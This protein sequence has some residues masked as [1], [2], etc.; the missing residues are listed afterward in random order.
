MTPNGTRLDGK[1]RES[2]CFFQLGGSDDGE[3]A[4]FLAAALQ[5]LESQAAFINH[6]RGSGG[7]VSFFVSW[8]PGD[9]GEVFDVQLL[10]DMARLG[11]DLGIEPL[12]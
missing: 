7:K 1:Y 11:I 2:Y 6:L 10:A 3:L 12:A 8:T 4:N 5:K 9:R